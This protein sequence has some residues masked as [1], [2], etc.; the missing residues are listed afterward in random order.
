MLSARTRAIS[1]DRVEKIKKRSDYDFPIQPQ[2][3]QTPIEVKNMIY[4]HF[5]KLGT[6]EHSVKL[7]LDEIVTN[8]LCS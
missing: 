2:F 3:H 1:S 5:H 7:E 4:R 8:S 6:K